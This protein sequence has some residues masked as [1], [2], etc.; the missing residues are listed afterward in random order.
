MLHLHQKKQGQG[1]EVVDGLVAVANM[2]RKCYSGFDRYIAL[3]NSINQN[4]DP[5]FMH[6]LQ[7]G[8]DWIHAASFAAQPLLSSQPSTASDA[9]HVVSAS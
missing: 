5:D 2:C 4:F 3:S 9:S 1:S 7:K 6:L 8:P